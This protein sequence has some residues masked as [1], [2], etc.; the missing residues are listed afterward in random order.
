MHV[1]VKRAKS[2][3]CVPAVEAH[4]VL[5]LCTW[6]TMKGTTIRRR[7]KN[8]RPVQSG[9]GREEREDREGYRRRRGKKALL[10][11]MGAGVGRRLDD[12]LI[13][14]VCVLE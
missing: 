4:T 2:R 8:K 5:L 7:Q 13:I 6:M 3:E 1:T 12:G 9:E 11:R 14:V 10:A